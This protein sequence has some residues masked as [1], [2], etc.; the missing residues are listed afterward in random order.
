M[1]LGLKEHVMAAIRVFAE[2]RGG[3]PRR[4]I[5]YRDG[6]AHNMFGMDKTGGQGPIQ[7]AASP[8]LDKQGLGY[9]QGRRTGPIQHPLHEMSS[10]AGDCT[11]CPPPQEIG[12]IFDAC[13][14]MRMPTPE[15]VFVVVQKR[16]RCRHS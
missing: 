12:H 8:S 14:T 10:S 4:I 1:L 2:Q 11:R 5:F 15:L 7:Q 16:N 9:G 13:E 6:V 3:P